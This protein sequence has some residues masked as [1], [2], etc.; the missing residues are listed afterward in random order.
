M[1]EFIS[2]TVEMI[3]MSNR[4]NPVGKHLIVKAHKLEE[5]DPIF[6]RI[7]AAGLEIPELKEKKLHERAV[8]RGTVLAISPSAW[9]DWFD[10]T[11]WCKV[12]DEIIFAK[13]GGHIIVDNEIEYVLLNDEDVL[14]VIS[15]ETK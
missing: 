13:Y 6:K 7:K 12:G 15:K 4:L 1:K 3:L 10:G 8:E 5:V 2:G 9:K 11:P 14:C